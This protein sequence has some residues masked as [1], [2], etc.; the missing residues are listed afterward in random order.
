MEEYMIVY[1]KEVYKSYHYL[2]MEVEMMLS[3]TMEHYT[4]LIK[5]AKVVG[6]YSI[7]FVKPMEEDN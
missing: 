5:I 4:S 6:S 2:T 7:Q 1:S 3:L